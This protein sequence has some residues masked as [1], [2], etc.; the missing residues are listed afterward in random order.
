MQFTGRRLTLCKSVF[1]VTHRLLTS[2][3]VC[4][5]V[6]APCAGSTVWNFEHEE[7][8]LICTQILPRYL[9]WK[10]NPQKG[11][12]MEKMKEWK[13]IFFASPPWQLAAICGWVGER[14]KNRGN[15]SLCWTCPR[16]MPGGNFNCVLRRKREREGDG[17]RWKKWRTIRKKIKVSTFH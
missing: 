7:S 14:S 12:K 4:K 8:K 9:L 10:W 13:P 3:S 6:C 2:Y 1:R 15:G 5:W 17:G 16:C 11:R